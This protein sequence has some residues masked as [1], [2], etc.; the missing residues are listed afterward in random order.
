MEQRVA[1]SSLAMLQAMVC[2]FSVVRFYGCHEIPHR[3]HRV[4]RAH[5]TE[6]QL[7]HPDDGAWVLTE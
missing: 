3:V 1:V 5:R 4:H 6:I 2:A 7:K